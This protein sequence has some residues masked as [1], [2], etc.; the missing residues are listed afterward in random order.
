MRCPTVLPDAIFFC[1]PKNNNL[2]QHEAFLQKLVVLG[3]TQFVLNDKKLTMGI[4]A[5]FVFNFPAILFFIELLFFGLLRTKSK[6]KKL[7]KVSNRAKKAE[8]ENFLLSYP[9]AVRENPPKVGLN[10][11]RFLKNPKFIWHSSMKGF[12]KVRF[13]DPLVFG[14]N[15]HFNSHLKIER[16]KAKDL[17]LKKTKKKLPL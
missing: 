4:N 3:P 14:P 8:F 1:N 9:S 12:G 15:K 13:K 17:I 11:I 6:L 7:K 10:R 5:D 16:I 2:P